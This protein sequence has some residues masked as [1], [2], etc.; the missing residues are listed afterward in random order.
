M[1]DAVRL[2]L[3]RD[4]WQG[5]IVI[6]SGKSLSVLE[7]VEEVREVTG[8]PAPVRH[9]P[10]GPGEM[11]AV[12]VDREPGARR[13]WS[14][15]YEFRD[16]LRG[17]WEEWCGGRS[18]HDPRR[19][20]AGAGDR[21][22]RAVVTAVRGTSADTGRGAAGQFDLD[23][24]LSRLEPAERAR[25]DGVPGRRIAPGLG[26]PLAIVIPAYNEEPT[27]AGVVGGDPALS[28]RPARPR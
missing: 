2:G 16:G 11:P 6:G 27:V 17:V 5:P 8:A 9:G 26:A 15:R 12:I 24:E 25:G 23:A 1:I 18:G 3:S 22:R 21:A 13:G 4:D 20:A 19:D 10:A 14:P 7:V 28:G